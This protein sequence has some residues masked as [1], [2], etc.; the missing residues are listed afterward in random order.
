MKMSI[1]DLPEKESN[2]VIITLMHHDAEWLDWE[3]KE[4]WNEYHKKY[5]DVIMVGHD[6]T[7]ECVRRK[8]YDNSTNK[9]IKGNQLYDH[10]SPEQSGFN[11]L[12]FIIEDEIIYEC[13][14]TYEWNGTIYTKIIETEREQFERNR[15][16]AYGIELKEEVLKYLEDLE[17]DIYNKKK[18]RELTLTDIFGFPTL[19]EDNG[20][21]I[22]FIRDMDELVEYQN[23]NRF[24]SIKGQKEYGKTALLKQLFKNYYMQKKFPVFLDVAKINS[25]DGEALNKIVEKKYKETYK[26]PN[27]DEIMQKN[28]EERI[29][30]IDNFEEI[31]LSDKS[32]KKFLQYLTT[33]FSKVILASNSRM[34][35]VKTLNYVETNDF[36]E[37]KFKTL[38]IQP[39]GKTYQ[40][41]IINRWMLLSEDDEIDTPSFD[42]KR[43][44]KYTQIEMVM[45]GG[46]FNKTPLDLLLVLS[47]LD[48]EAPTQIDYSR[49]SF[50]YEALILDKLNLIGNKTTRE[51]VA[52]KTILQNIAYKMFCDGSLGIIEEKDV[53]GIIE[54][55]KE[56]HLGFKMS[57]VDVVN[58]LKAF[59]FLEYK[60]NLYSFRY[61]YMYY[62]FAGSHINKN[63]C[64][65]EKAKVVKK[66]FSNID[67][68][69]NYNIALFLAYDLN[70]GHDIFPVVKEIEKDLLYSFQEYR[71]EKVQ[72]M[73]EA[74]GGD[75]EKKVEERIVPKNENIPYLREKKLRELEE[76]EMEE[77]IEEGNISPPK[78]S[79]EQIEK[80]NIDVMKT[81]HLINF[82]GNLLKNY[83]GSMDNSLR[84]ET[85][86]LMFKLATKVLGSVCSLS[87]KLV[88][89]LIEMLEEKIEEGVEED[90]LVKSDFVEKVKQLLAIIWCQFISFNISALSYNLEC[91]DIKENLDAYCQKNNF[92]FVKM[93]RVEYLIRIAST[94]L[95]VDDIKELFNGKNK[96]EDISQNIFKNNVYRYLSSYQ[97]DNKDRQ[98]ICS[99]LGFSMKD[100]LL[101]EKKNLIVQN[102]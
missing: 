65:A 78:Y 89:G 3:D 15:Y 61:S 19:K 96:I 22:K 102:K 92:D 64:A 47:Y 40:E 35:L 100:V 10:S 1:E 46:F 54:T 97:F 84:Q 48:Q 85:I 57:A 11:I 60:N 77:S 4:V 91:D 41:R 75:I 21:V 95:P 20:K 50:I 44:E 90:I 25:A 62:Y 36:I 93:V 7:T 94:K 59:K 13:F 49:Y 83:S 87:E 26:N 31:Q 79:D 34:D 30:L 2:D 71:Y 53:L 51:S 73:L 42:A 58:K 17:I 55:Y 27:V 70:I 68:E 82:M 12:K 37:D 28:A 14:F 86:D 69:L 38:I 43:R 9:Y 24:I 56:N 16:L 29:C 99:L 32:T 98:T 80:I 33:K 8:N 72:Q 18:K 81:G 23:T 101:E 39:V 63:L 88:D 5:S 76:I 67:T 52:Y 74:W 66:I 45:K 6:H